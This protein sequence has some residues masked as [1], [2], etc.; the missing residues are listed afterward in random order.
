MSEQWLKP[1]DL[2]R[3]RDEDRFRREYEQ[4]PLFADDSRQAYITADGRHRYWLTR[5]WHDDRPMMGFIM[6]NPSTADA[7]RNDPTLTRCVNYAH[8]EGCGGVFLVNLYAGRTPH[9]SELANMGDPIG[10]ENADWI[11]YVLRTRRISPI[12]VGWG[13]GIRRLPLWVDALAVVIERA[14]HYR[15]DLE[16][17]GVAKDGSPRHP[18]YLKLEAP[19]IPWE[20]PEWAVQAVTKHFAEQQRS[21]RRPRL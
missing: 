19:L 5:T 14:A 3:D 4:A 18:L 8:R 9:P 7:E 17:L 6:L 10:V 15:R 11:D 2:A 16:C 12:V 1:S 20:V 13:E 21:R